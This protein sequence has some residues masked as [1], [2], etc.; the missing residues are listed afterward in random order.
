[1]RVVHRRPA[2]AVQVEDERDLHQHI[3]NLLRDPGFHAFYQGRSYLHDVVIASPHS[4]VS[5]SVKL[6]LRLH[7]YG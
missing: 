6:S 7:P 4:S 1:M 5:R 2:D 3:T